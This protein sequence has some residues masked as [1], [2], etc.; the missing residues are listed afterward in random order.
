[1]SN[2]EYLDFAPMEL[3]KLLGNVTHYEVIFWG[4]RFMPGSPGVGGV[5]AEIVLYKDSEELGRV[6]F[7]DPGYYETPERWPDNGYT[8]VSE[9]HFHMYL[10]LAMFENVI[11]IL[12]NEKPI[13]YHFRDGHA[14]LG[15]FGELAGEAE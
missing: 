6:R 5:R 11:D 3:D 12:R 7:P 4:S 2:D 14:F 9:T 13:S 8:E 15:T 10:P 1:L